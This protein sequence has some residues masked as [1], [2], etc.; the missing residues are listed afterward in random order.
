VRGNT[1]PARRLAAIS[2]SPSPSPRSWSFGEPADPSEASRTLEID[3]L[4]SLRFDP[5]VVRVEPGEAVTFR[6]H[7]AGAL[8]HEFMIGTEA[9]QTEAEVRGARDPRDTRDGPDSLRLDSGETADITW[10]FSTSST[11]PVFFACHAPG[12]FPAG[13]KGRVRIDRDR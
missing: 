10:R 12:H 1:R 4:D 8:A 5:A 6:V 13:M 7:N 2:T 11:A 3:A 9:D